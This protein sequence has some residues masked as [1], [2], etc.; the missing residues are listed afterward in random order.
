MQSRP[1]RRRRSALAAVAF[2]LALA[3]CAGQRERM[4]E[5]A[6]TD[7]LARYESVVED[8]D[9]RT[10]GAIFTPSFNAFLRSDRR[11]RAAGDVLTVRLVENMQGSSSAKNSDKRN[12][13]HEL[14]VSTPIASAAGGLLK[15]V[16]SVFLPDGKAGSTARRVE[17]ILTDNRLGTSHS[18]AGEGK[19]EK[20]N[21]MD[22]FITVTVERVFPNGN[23]FVTGRKQVETDGG[24][25]H[26]RVRGIVRPDDI[27]AD[28]IVASTRIAQAEIGYVAAGDRYY[29]ARE[30]WLGRF[31]NQIDPL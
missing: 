30:G 20:S 18:F 11:A 2:P 21:T 28:N 15:S 1:H 9:S 16:A 13:S 3:G 12:G 27:T 10:A 26:V 25:E 22:G 4:V 7:Y 17:D 23:L 8:A 14:S 5:E 6:S 31:F 29:A 24:T 19:L